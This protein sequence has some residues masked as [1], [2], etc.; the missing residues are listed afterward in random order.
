MRSEAALA[1]RGVVPLLWRFAFLSYVLRI[2]IT[3]AQRYTA[4][5]FT[6]TDVQV[7]HIF[8]AFLIGDALLQIRVGML[9]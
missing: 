3:V 6:F 7:G 9:A 8:S 4:R 1:R 5:E 2:N